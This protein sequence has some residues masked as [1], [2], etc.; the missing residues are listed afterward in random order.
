MASSPSTPRLHVD[1]WP[2][3]YGA[4]TDLE[5]DL[6]PAAGEL[7][8]TLETADW[9]PLAPPAEGDVATVAFVDGVRR[10]DARLTLDDPA[11]P[12]PGLCGSLAV[13]AVVWDRAVPRSTCDEGS[14][15]VRRLAVLEDHRRREMPPLR[16]GLV[17]EPLACDRGLGALVQTLQNEMRAEEGRLAQ[18]LAARHD[19]VVADG[20]LHDPLAAPGVVGYVKSHRV[21]YLP[22]ELAATVT[23]LGAGERTPLFLFGPPAYRRW[24]WYLRLARVPGGHSWSGIVRCEQAGSVP[25]DDARRRADVTARLLP[26]A[27]SALH[28][29]PRAP[30]NLVPIGALERRLR[31]ALGDAGL[32]LRALRSA[33][34]E[35]A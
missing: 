16:Y 27:A 11:G 35:A 26:L 8:A 29:D 5:G 20:P 23:G 13:G 12:I 28:L 10:L 34:R 32:V 30:Q 9:R 31:R 3:G 24:S 7:D 4:A 21:A 33:L 14:F 2:P 15:R 1:G 18:A 6:A 25:L 17:F 22:P 19:L